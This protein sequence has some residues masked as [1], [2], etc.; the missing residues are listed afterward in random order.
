MKNLFQNMVSAIRFGIRPEEA[1]LAATLTPAR[2]LGMDAEIGSL[3]AGKKADRL[4]QKATD[5]A[6]KAAEELR[7][8]A[9]SRLSEAVGIVRQIISE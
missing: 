2:E 8:Q 4:S 5:R 9:D 7:A 1:V 3:A 6:E